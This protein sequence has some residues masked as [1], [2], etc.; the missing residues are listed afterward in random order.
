MKR[1]GFWEGQ[2]SNPIEFSGVV[3]LEEIEH[4]FY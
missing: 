1:T 3:G 2:G 4:S